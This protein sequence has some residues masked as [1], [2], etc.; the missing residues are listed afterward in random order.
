M[1]CMVQSV[2]LGG[3][4]KLAHRIIYPHRIINGKTVHLV[5]YPR[6]AALGIYQACN[7]SQ[8]QTGE[9]TDHGNDQHRRDVVSIKKLKQHVAG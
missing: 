2:V 7:L 6:I 1:R 4:I 8:K 9:R 3:K 5:I